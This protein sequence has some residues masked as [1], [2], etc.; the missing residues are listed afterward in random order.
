MYEDRYW[1]AVMERDSGVDGQFVYAVR[2]TGIYCRPSCP[3]RRPKRE[4]VVFFQQPMAAEEAG[5][6]ACKRCRPRE[7]AADPQ[8]E[9]AQR[10]CDAI[11][12]RLDDMPGLAELSSQVNVSPYHLQRVFKRVMGISPR[13]YAEARR[14][15]R[16]KEQLKEG[17][18]VTQALYGVGFSSSSRLYERAPDQLGMTPTVYR[19]G[20]PGMQITYTIVDCSLGR[21]LVA[22]TDK[23]ICSVCIGDDDT[24]LEAALLHE[25]PRAEMRRDDGTR[26]GDDFHAWV[27]MLVQHLGGDQPHL[28]LPVDVQATAFQWRVWQELRAIPYGA[29]RSYSQVA[30]AIGQPTAARAVARAC[31]TNPIAIVVPCHRVVRENGQMGGYRWGIERKER[32]LAQEASGKEDEIDSRFSSSLAVAKPPLA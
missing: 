7:N 26:Y 6:R 5:F 18:T 1:Q 29:T 4:E 30:Q 21:L 14:L 15:D 2:S 16:F 12:Q 27:E 17:E 3:S 8:V 28:D 24:K 19:R 13:Q 11:E 20:G 31:A 9:L 32:L 23:G 10:V 25:Y 22:A